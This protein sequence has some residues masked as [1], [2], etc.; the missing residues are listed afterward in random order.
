[1]ATRW[2][3][4]PDNWRGPGLLE[5]FEPD[6]FHEVVDGALAGLDARELERQP[7]VGEHRPP[8]QQ[9]GLLE[10]D[11]E[12][13][14]A[15]RGRGIL[16]VHERFTARRGLEI[17]EDPQDRRLPAARRA[18][19]RGE[20]AIRR[21]EVD[22]LERDDLGTADLEDLAELAQRDAVVRDD[23]RLGVGGVDAGQ[24]LEGSHVTQA[25]S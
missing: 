5:S 14:I 10:R 9:R 17:G 22:A 4:P 23:G 13:V 19:Q 16:S 20:R 2:R 6:E 25:L 15:A 18:E 7:D 12:M 21:S 11:A 24:G 8:R 1:M 3:M